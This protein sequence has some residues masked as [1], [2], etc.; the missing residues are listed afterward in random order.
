MVAIAVAYGSAF[1]PGGAPAWAP[2]AL[3]LGMSTT[4]VAMMVMGSARNGRIGK[5]AIPFG[6]V[7]LVLVGGFGFALAYPGTDAVNPELWLG[8]PPRAAVILYVIGFGPLLVM[9]LAYA[10]T[11][12]QQT[13]RPEDL[14]R[15]RQHRRGTDADAALAAAG[16]PRRL[17]P[18][19][20]AR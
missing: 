5:L 16:T 1:L 2:W 10:L 18:E 20:V 14:E 7:F 6:F 15:V 8:L 4:M 9:P 12:D 3:M 17:E 19:E 13:L 11:F